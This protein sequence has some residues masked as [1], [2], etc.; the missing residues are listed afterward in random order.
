M[1][2]RVGINTHAH[3]FLS[4][5]FPPEGNA[6]VSRVYVC[7]RRWVEQRHEVTV[8]T[9]APN[10]AG[11]VVYPGYRNR[12][13]QRE[14]IDG[15]TVI[16]MWTLLAANRGTMKRV[17]NFFSFMVSATCNG[18]FRRCPDVLVTTSPRFFCGWVGLV[19]ARLN[20]VLFVFEVRDL[21]PESIRAVGAA[22]RGPH[23]VSWNG[24]SSACTGTVIAW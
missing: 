19:L 14:V 3:S 9:C 18:L 2:V 21:C 5:Y 23:C 13:V 16:R 8:I 6:T 24:W 10:V 11:G 20:R 1:R 7:A 22:C 12:L 17:L 4:H 15:I